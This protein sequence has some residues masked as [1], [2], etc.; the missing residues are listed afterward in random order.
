[1]K[2]FVEHIQFLRIQPDLNLSRYGPKIKTGTAG[3]TIT[4]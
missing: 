4:K 1:M 3:K 2:Y